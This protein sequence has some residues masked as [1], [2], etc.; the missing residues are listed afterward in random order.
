MGGLRLVDRHVLARYVAPAVFLLA[1]TGIVLAVRAGLRS[2]SG[3]STTTTA[4][5]ATVARTTVSRRPPAAPARY[6]VIQPGDTL[7]AI[8]SQFGTAVTVLVRLNP[9]VEPTA[10]TPGEQIRIR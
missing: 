1:V 6:Y 8:A 3:G 4:S 5:V 9:G 10:L 7:G 2:D